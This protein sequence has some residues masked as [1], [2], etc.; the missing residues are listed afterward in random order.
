VE[1]ELLDSGAI[2]GHSVF[3]R[4][5]QKNHHSLQKKKRK[6]C[7]SN[8]YTLEATKST[9]FFYALSSSIG[10][11]FDFFKQKILTK[12]LPLPLLTNNLLN[13]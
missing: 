13:G 3:T 12:N 5:L 11:F 1:E 4:G 8:T 7:A 6:A 9:H 10:I 2:M